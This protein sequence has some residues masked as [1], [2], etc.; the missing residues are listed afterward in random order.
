MARAMWNGVMSF[1]L[2]NVPVRLHSAVRSERP[3][4]HLLHAKDESPVHYQRICE[5]EGKVV[6]WS[7]VV[8]GHEVSKGEYAVLT[9]EDFKRA[10]LDR[11]E[12]IDILAFV[13]TGTIDARYF[14]TPYYLAPAKGGERAYALLRETMA[15]A[16]KTA[17]AQIVLRQA[18]H[19]GAIT[20]VD[21]VLVFTTLRF[22]QEIVNPRTLGL[23]QKSAPR[24]SELDLAAKLIDGIAGDWK[25][26]QYKDRYSENLLAIIK[27]KT[28]KGSRPRLGE[29]GP[30]PAGGGEV[31]DLMERLRASLAGGRAS[32]APAKRAT[33]GPRTAKRAPAEPRAAK[34]APA[35]PRAAKRQTPASHRKIATTRRHKRAA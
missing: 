2:V 24:Q 25:P 31:A 20:A 32:A 8:K 26:E 9:P 21:E 29:L 12:T 35:E 3:H 33:A 23:P 13:P 1:G 11:S 14:E 18:Q 4:F 5:R 7:E 30:K 6:P 10:A 19:L 17:V 34:R 16:T 22:A 27:S 28:K 15:K